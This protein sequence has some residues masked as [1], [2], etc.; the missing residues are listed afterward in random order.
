[1]D[2]DEAAA[3]AATAPAAEAGA[4]DGGGEEKKKS[5][6]GTPRG[7]EMTIPGYDPLKRDP[8]FAFTGA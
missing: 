8:R 5:S 6:G 7:A 4:G 2:V 3:A 1:M